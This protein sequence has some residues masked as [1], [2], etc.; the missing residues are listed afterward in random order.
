MM[1]TVWG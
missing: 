1:W